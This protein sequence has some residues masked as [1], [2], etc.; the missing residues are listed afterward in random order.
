MTKINFATLAAAITLGVVTSG[1]ADQRTAPVA[2][3]KTYLAANQL[4][5]RWQGEPTAIESPEIRAAYPGRAFYFTYAA[6]PVPPGAPMPAVLARYEQ[7]MA[8]YRKNSLRMTVGID[9][10]QT[11]VSVEK[12][13]DF[14]QGLAPVKTDADARAAAAAI[15]SLINSDTVRPAVIHASE[16]NVTQ[17]AAGWTCVVKQQ[18]KGI[19][20]TVVFDRSGKCISTSKELNYALQ[21]PP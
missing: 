2:A 16:V 12:A 20:G 18:P 6:P 7:A 13:E 8:E 17:T 14:N 4:D 19:D 1:I 15:L 3:F 21:T 9:A 10:A 11:V 5:A